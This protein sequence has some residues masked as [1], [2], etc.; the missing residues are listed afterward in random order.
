MLK[1][2]CAEIVELV[3]FGQSNFFKK[4][5][6]MTDRFLVFEDCGS[7]ICN[8]CLDEFMELRVDPLEYY[9]YNF[10]ESEILSVAKEYVDYF[11]DLS[12]HEI[13]DK[14]IKYVTYDNLLDLVK[15]EVK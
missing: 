9:G 14:I 11:L 10:L 8:P 4:E 6:V 2:K 15:V 1:S 13:A 3:G 12:A 5:G 7:T